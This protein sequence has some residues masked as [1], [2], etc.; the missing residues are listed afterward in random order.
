MS[1]TD[2][3]CA[4]YEGSSRLIWH[5]SRTQLNSSFHNYVAD[6]AQIVCDFDDNRWKKN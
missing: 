6:F 1:G 3:N 4:R 5:R 2:D